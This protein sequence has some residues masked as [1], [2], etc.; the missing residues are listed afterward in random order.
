MDEQS[1]YHGKTE[2]DTH[3]VPDTDSEDS[4]E[5]STESDHFNAAKFLHE[6]RAHAPELSTESGYFNAAKPLHD[7]Q[8]HAPIYINVGGTMYCTSEKTLNK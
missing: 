1:L 7:S 2:S 6:S 3:L 5:F 4:Y 8:A